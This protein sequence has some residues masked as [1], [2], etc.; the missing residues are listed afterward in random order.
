MELKTDGLSS[1]KYG[2]DPD[3]LLSCLS[4]LMLEPQW[5]QS[6][7]TATGG[8]RRTES[9]LISRA[10]VE[11]TLSLDGFSAKRPVGLPIPNQVRA[12]SRM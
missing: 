11:E 6:R 4:R 3:V 1:S 8:F 9:A 7:C 12:L 5:T 2:P 10:I